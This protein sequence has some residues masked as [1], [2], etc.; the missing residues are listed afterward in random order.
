MPSSATRDALT[1]LFY[2]FCG[3][4]LL[5]NMLVVL[6]FFVDLKLRQFSHNIYI[7]N[8]ALTDLLFDINLIVYAA[9]ISQ[10]D[11]TPGHTSAACSATGWP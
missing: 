2:I 5:L 1:A 10:R 9:A 3:C 11:F 7:L 8:L 6:A 4:G